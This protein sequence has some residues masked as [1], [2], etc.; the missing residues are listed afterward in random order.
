MKKTL[1]E[2]RK[3]CAEAGRRLFLDLAYFFRIHLMLRLLNTFLER[4]RWR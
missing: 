4:S 2:C 1:E 3:E